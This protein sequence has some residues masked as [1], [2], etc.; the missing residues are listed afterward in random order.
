MKKY[1]KYL[2][3]A[4]LLITIV[5]ITG[6]SAEDTSN[7]SSS[8]NTTLNSVNN[9]VN[10][11]TDDNVSDGNVTPVENTSIDE[12]TTPV[13]ENKTFNT[14]VDISVDNSS[15]YEPSIVNISVI[16]DNN[17]TV[18]GGNISVIIKYDDNGTVYNKTL[19]VTDG[20]AI[21]QWTPTITGKYTI[22]VDFNGYTADNITYSTSKGSKTYNAIANNNLI[23]IS[24]NV[25]MYYKDGTKYYVFVTDIDGNPISNVSVEINIAGK[26]YKRITNENGTASLSLNLSPKTY[27]VTTSVVNSTVTNSS[28]VTINNWNNSLI[29]VNPVKLTKEYK[30]SNNFK[31][32]ISH[33]GTALQNVPVY[34]VIKGKTYKATTDNS[35]LA[36]LNINLKPGKYNVYAY[37]VNGNKIG[38]YS[39]ITV[40]KW[41]KKYA[42][43]TVNKVVKNYADSNKI[44][45]KLTYK[46]HGISGEKVL[47]KVAG[48]TYTRTTNSNGD[49]SMSFNKI[50]TYKVSASTNVVGVKVSGS[51]T[52]KVNP[53][54][55]NLL[56]KNNVN[57]YT[58]QSD[59]K[60]KLALF[61]N[62][63]KK[64]LDSK[65][66]TVNNKLKLQFTYNNKPRV[67]QYV[68]VTING[69]NTVYKTDKNGRIYADISKAKTGC[70]YVTVIYYSFD[71]N[72]Y[73]LK[74]SVPVNF[75]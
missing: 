24:N 3:L 13:V 22:N 23:I 43:L 4:L 60:G 15:V 73:S 63:N 68:S 36:Q 52:V 21:I 45:V 50:G 31:V 26:S 65:N 39:T 47:I 25:V 67:Q 2:V 28:S 75:R 71:K 33:N 32:Y 20:K 44:R 7:Y 48:K 56:V 51:N 58:G 40:N 38:N 9:N 69:K 12:N 53:A 54:Y 14:N 57:S 17:A 30:L 16:G 62:I 42:K 27:N 18:N 66:K 35:G 5:T 11:L 72:Y 1:S 70:Q 59:N 61:Y 29:K 8:D 41:N 74:W 19:P 55:V 64:Y 37:V 49:V 6:V 34:I 10:I 46:N